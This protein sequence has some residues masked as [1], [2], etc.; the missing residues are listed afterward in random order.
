MRTRRRRPAPALAFA[1]A[2]LAV[3]GPAPGRAQ[4]GM[5]EIAVEGPRPLALAL[6][7]L[8][9]RHG[10]P[11]SYEDPVYVFPGDLADVTLEVRRDLD[12]FAAGT[13]PRVLVPASGRVEV[14]YAMGEGGILEHPA[15]VVQALLDDHAARGNP[16]RFRLIQETGRFFVVPAEVR[17]AHGEWVAARSVLETQVTLPAQPRSGPELLA[18]LVAAVGRAA[19]ARVILGVAP[20][21]PLL[22]ARPA[23]GAAGEPARQVLVRAL[24]TGEAT[25]RRR[26]AWQLFYDPGLKLHVLNLHFPGGGERGAQPPPAQ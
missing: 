1:L 17:D 25:A 20:V 13:A 2:A 6:E 3:L 15:A 14:R 26:L 22:R 4:Q 21:E 24:A 16:G 7:T 19:G 10:L 23:F 5:A 9:A 12:R 11:I 8:A 18:A